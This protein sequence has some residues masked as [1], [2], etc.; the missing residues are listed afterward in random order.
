LLEFG[1][2]SALATGH[3]VGEHEDLLAVALDVTDTAAEAAV[4]A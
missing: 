3:A 1:T 2:C 4:H